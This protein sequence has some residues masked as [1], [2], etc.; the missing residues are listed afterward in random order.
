MIKHKIG[1]I[2]PGIVGYFRF[3]DRIQRFFYPPGR[4]CCY[5]TLNQVVK[6]ENLGPSRKIFGTIAIICMPFIGNI[7]MWDKQTANPET[8]MDFFKK[9]DDPYCKKKGVDG[10]PP[11]VFKIQYPMKIYQIRYKSNTSFF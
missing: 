4:A 7:L 11:P 10:N 5:K 9:K 8:G 6:K 1:R 3:C 2:A